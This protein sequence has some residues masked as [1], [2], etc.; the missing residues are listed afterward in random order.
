MFGDYEAQRHWME[1]T[2]ALPIEGWYKPQDERQALINPPEY[3]GLDYPLLTAYVS[4]VC[5]IIAKMFDPRP[6]EPIVSRGFKLPSSKAYM[7]FTVVFL[8]CAIFFTAAWAFCAHAYGN[9]GSGYVARKWAHFKRD[10]RNYSF[11]CE[12]YLLLLLSPGII[13][14]DHGHFQQQLRK[15]RV[16]RRRARISAS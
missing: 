1:V 16:C 9:G 8:D 2:T 11:A 7:R 3:W 13:L 12:V 6:V 14:I 15:P 5:G 4:Y 10:K